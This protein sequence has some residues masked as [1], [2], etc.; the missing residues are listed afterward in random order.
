MFDIFT[1]FLLHSIYPSQT[2]GMI[3]EIT[4]DKHSTMWYDVYRR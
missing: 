1:Y 2:L 3:F 4:I